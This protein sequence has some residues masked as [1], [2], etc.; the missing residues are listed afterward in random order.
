MARRPNIR[1]NYLDDARFCLRLC[2]AIERDDARPLAWR[3]E[4]ISD[5]NALAQKFLNAPKVK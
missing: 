2:D 3:E 1:E 4:V 5:L